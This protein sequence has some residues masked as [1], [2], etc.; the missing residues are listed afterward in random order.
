MWLTGGAE[1]AVSERSMVPSSPVSRHESPAPTPRQHDTL[2]KAKPVAPT[3]PSP[4]PPSD[5]DTRAAFNDFEP[6][7]AGGETLG[8]TKYIAPFPDAGARCVL[9]HRVSVRSHFATDG[10]PGEQL[11]G[12]DVAGVPL[13]PD[14]TPANGSVGLV[15]AAEP[16]RE[17]RHAW[18]GVFGGEG[19]L[20]VTLMSAIAHLA[21][22]NV[23][24]AFARDEELL[25]R[26]AA[27]R[28]FTGRVAG[29]D[30][31][32]FSKPSNCDD[33]PC[34]VSALS[35]TLL[36]AWAGVGRRGAAF[37]RNGSCTEYVLSG[38]GMNTVGHSVAEPM[39]AFVSPVGAAPAAESPGTGRGDF[40]NP[41]WR[42]GPFA[43]DGFDYTGLAPP[44]P[45][46]LPALRLLHSRV[47]H[48]LRAVFGAGP[49]V[50]ASPFVYL[51]R[52]YHPGSPDDAAPWPGKRSRGIA[53]A[54]EARLLDLLS[55]LQLGSADVV[56]KDG[57]GGRVDVAGT[58]P[59]AT[60]G[61]PMR[62]D[63]SSSTPLKVQVEALRDARLVLAGEGA[64]A[65]W[66][67]VSPPGATWVIVY[68]HYKRPGEFPDAFF[69][70]WLPRV[71]RT[72]RIILYVVDHG[73]AGSVDGLT[74]A[75]L[76]P[77]RPE[78]MVV[79]PR[80]VDALRLA[81]LESRHLQRNATPAST[82][83]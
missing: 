7:I 21:L 31:L 70:R 64:A 42:E 32:L 79:A 40:D 83:K 69:Q 29:A 55:P 10:D 71:T 24:E 14:C 66:T 50:A 43:D 76:R 72:V 59:N 27:D 73:T 1:D 57:S 6:V 19:L 80:H 41:A 22:G 39:S 62:A 52:R 47:Y 51:Q 28:S 3:V 2:P 37:G 81:W 67:L 30:A 34:P 53:P 63:F 12:N 75:L 78:W 5:A 58:N 44:V 11:M 56:G 20:Q 25:R 61:S 60:Y 33:D 9:Y 65:T 13:P 35:D 36:R 38:S 74:D 49:A 54:V 82:E 8:I 18:H 68:E 4:W 16:H 48:S 46:Q 26:A 17:L 23:R 77:W 15:F 45:A